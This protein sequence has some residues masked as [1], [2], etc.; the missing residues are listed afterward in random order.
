MELKMPKIT[1]LSNDVSNSSYSFSIRGV[2][3]V[4]FEDFDGDGIADD[5]DPDDDNDGLTDVEEDELGTSSRNTDS[6]DDEIRDMQEV[7]DGTDPMDSGSGVERLGQSVCTEWNGFLDYL[8]QVLELRNT[9]NTPIIVNTTLYDIAGVVQST[10]V[11][12]LLPNEQNDLVVN[13]MDGF[14]SNS[15]GLICSTIVEGPE[16]SLGGQYAHYLYQGD[17]YGYAWSVPF[18]KGKKNSQ[19]TSYNT[20]FQRVTS[21]NLQTL[22][23]DLFKSQMKNYRTGRS[24]SLLRCCRIRV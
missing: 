19:C 20:F 11:R 15:Y 14:I 13:V 23:R 2:R 7:I 17:T 21:L 5:L 22:S 10:A 16:N 6:D 3:S 18:A 8:L 4:T 12:S 24:F 9:S 1:V